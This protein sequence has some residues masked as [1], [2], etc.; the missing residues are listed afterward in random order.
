MMRIAGALLAGLS[1]LGL[2]VLRGAVAV[3]NQMNSASGGYIPLRINDI[4]SSLDVLL[5][6]GAVLAGLALMFWPK[7]LPGE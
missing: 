6:Y 4:A 5:L 1:L 2:A 7:R 3:V